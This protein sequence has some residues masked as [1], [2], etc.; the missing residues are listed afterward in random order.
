MTIFALGKRKVVVNFGSYMNSWV[1]GML[2]IFA[3]SILLMPKYFVPAM[4]VIYFV[5]LVMFFV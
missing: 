4:L 2:Y 3:R 1:I 5:L